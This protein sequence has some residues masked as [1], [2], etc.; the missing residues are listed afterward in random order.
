M[1]LWF[2]YKEVG[3]KTWGYSEHTGKNHFILRE[4]PPIVFSLE[5]DIL[6]KK[7]QTGRSQGLST[8]FWQIAG[9]LGAHIACNGGDGCQEEVLSGC[10]VSV[11]DCAREGFSR[12][13]PGRLTIIPVAGF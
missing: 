12:A 4:H 1:A 7:R 2:P 6:Q 10:R 9:D 11:L 5:I 13:K 8:G 3:I